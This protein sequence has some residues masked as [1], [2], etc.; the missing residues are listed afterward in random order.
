MRG[1][2]AGR[3]ALS[4]AVTVLVCA[5][6][7]AARRA[8]AAIVFGQLDTF[9]S[10]TT[11][12]WDKGFRTSLP[13]ANVAGGDGGAADRYLRSESIGGFSADSRQ[14]ILNEQQWA[15]NYSTAGVTRIE[16][17]LANLGATPLHMRVALI[18]TSGTAY[19]SRAARVLPADGNWYRVYFDLT[20]AGLAST[21][22]AQPL[23][24][25]LA[26]VATLRLLSVEAR[27]SER[28]DPIVS[29]LGVD[30]VRALRL[31]GDADFD[32]RVSGADF[33]VVRSNLGSTA[34]ATWDR[35]DFN[36][37]G[38][39]NARDMHLLRRHLGQSNAPAPAGA[40]AIAAAVPEP[41]VP[42]AFFAAAFLLRRR[43]RSRPPRPGWSVRLRKT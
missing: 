17:S 31:P 32:G 15:G 42:C 14:I 30:D 1:Q 35:G 16:A 19:A 6:P 12:G 29:T 4:F 3:L 28:A 24:Q 36:F 8:G 25:V 33:A 5:T 39:V 9:Q 41:I 18:G 27:P 13:P 11:L 20:P 38:R 37:D 7:G 23:N 10:G 34:G 43:R 2:S 22:G 21:G 26:S 40:P